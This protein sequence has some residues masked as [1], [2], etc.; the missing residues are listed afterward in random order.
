MATG[1][2]ILY[3]HCISELQ[4]RAHHSPSYFFYNTEKESVIIHLGISSEDDDDD[5]A[6]ECMSE[7]QS[8]VQD[9][10]PIQSQLPRHT[11]SHL[12]S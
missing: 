11:F 2:T 10:K 4:K 12:V 5:D 8:S 1:V 3:Y 7:V 9:N 6:C